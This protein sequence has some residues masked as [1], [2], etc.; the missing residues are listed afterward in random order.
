MLQKKGK[1]SGKK[2]S[3]STRLRFAIQNRLDRLRDIETEPKKVTITTIIFLLHHH[4]RH[5]R[6][7]L[8]RSY[9]HLHH[10]LFNTHCQLLIHFKHHHRDLIVLLEIFVFLH[11]FHLELL[12]TE[13]QDYLER[14]L[15]H[16]HRLLPE[17]KK[18]KKFF[19]IVFKR[20]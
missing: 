1:R 14:Y 2:R 4:H 17:K 6:M 3:G 5:F 9:H 19:R 13:S 16:R 11:N 7:G 8:V 10:H 12:V 15:A 18:K 20:N